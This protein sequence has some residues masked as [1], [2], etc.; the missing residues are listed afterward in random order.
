MIPQSDGDG[1]GTQA[2]TPDR[3][4]D[5]EQ[6]QAGRHQ[7]KDMLLHATTVNEPSHQTL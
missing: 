7:Q 4:G 3:E 6:A 2:C 5:E 1:N